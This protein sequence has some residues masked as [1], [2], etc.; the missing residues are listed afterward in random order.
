M[1]LDLLAVSEEQAN[2][3]ADQFRLSPERLYQRILQTLLDEEPE[4]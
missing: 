4:E 3:L 2:Q 1:T